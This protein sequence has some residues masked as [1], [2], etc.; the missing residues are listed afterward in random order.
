MQGQPNGVADAE[1]E[2]LRLV[3]RLARKRIAGRRRAI[4]VQAQDLSEVAARA[5]SVAR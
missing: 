1:R 2:D 3:L 4:V 5:L